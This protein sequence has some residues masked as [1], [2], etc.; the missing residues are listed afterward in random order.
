[1]KLFLSMLCLLIGSLFFSSLAFSAVF[2]TFKQITLITEV[3]NIEQQLSTLTQ[4][5]PLEDINDFIATLVL[6][7]APLIALILII[8]SQFK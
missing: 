7:F 2:D 4:Y 6:V 5:L 1:M 8:R 3:G